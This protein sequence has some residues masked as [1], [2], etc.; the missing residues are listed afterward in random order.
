VNSISYT[1]IADRFTCVA[2]VK[3]SDLNTDMWKFESSQSKESRAQSA[4]SSKLQQTL[5]F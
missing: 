4:D 3:T 2:F 5:R 1:K